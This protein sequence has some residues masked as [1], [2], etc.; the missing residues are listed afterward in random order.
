MEETEKKLK[1]I[2]KIVDDFNYFIDVNPRFL[3]TIKEIEA[4]FFIIDRLNFILKYGIEIDHSEHS[5]VAFLSFK[6]FIKGSNI[7][8]SNTIKENEEQYRL[9]KELRREYDEWVKLKMLHRENPDDSQLLHFLEECDERDA[10][11]FLPWFTQYPSSKAI[12]I[13]SNIIKEDYFSN[14]S[15]TIG[16]AKMGDKKVLSWAIK[17]LDQDNSFEERRIILKCIAFSPHQEAD[18]ILKNIIKAS[19]ANNIDQVDDIECLAGILGESTSKNK[20]IRL[21]QIILKPEKS[22][23]LKKI[24]ELSIRNLFDENKEIAIELLNKLNS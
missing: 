22:L 2:K 15:I 21:E 16:L 23:T 1:Y 5:W 13:Y 12:S 3:G 19:R 4:N 7:S 9:L 20:F 6:E 14:P 10:H 18:D 11:K 17:K 8:I 24:L